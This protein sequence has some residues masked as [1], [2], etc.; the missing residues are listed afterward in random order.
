MNRRAF[1]GRV[2]ALATAV[3]LAPTVTAEAASTGV[4]PSLNAPS[5]IGIRSHMPQSCLGE[6]GCTVRVNERG[7]D[8]RLTVIHQGAGF[9][10][11]ML[12]SLL[13][14]VA[15]PETVEATI[16]DWAR[17]R[18]EHARKIPKVG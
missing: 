16:A 12:V 17:D 14:I 18:H 5:T 15:R 8:Y 6:A 3:G 2:S 13:D 9:C 1:L 7:Y 4:G 11:V 10:D